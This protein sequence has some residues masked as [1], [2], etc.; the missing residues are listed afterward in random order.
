MGQSVPA[1]AKDFKVVFG[2]TKNFAF[3]ADLSIAIECFVHPIDAGNQRRVVRQLIGLDA[4]FAGKA[5][6]PRRH[7]RVKPELTP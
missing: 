6:M 2:V 5:R 1:A 3:L 4:R 7:I